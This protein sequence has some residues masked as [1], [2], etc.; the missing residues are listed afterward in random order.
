[1]LEIE[2]KSDEL[3][4]FIYLEL[5][6][7][8]NDPIY[9]EDLSKITEIT[10]NGLDLIG[11][12]TDISIYDLIF[13]KNL[14]TLYISDKDISDK[15]LDIINKL[16]NLRFLQLDNC[17]FSDN[18]KMNLELSGLVINNCP[19]VKINIYSDIKTL[20]TLHIVNCDNVDIS[21]IATLSN[22]EKL[23]LQNLTLEEINE[24]QELKKLEYLS[25]NGSKIKDL[26]KIY[27]IPNLKI[28]NEEIFGIYDEEY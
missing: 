14:T 18:K 24:V 16:S 7:K 28:D 3:K 21:G 19:K 4:E 26:E 10:L 12:P 15:E 5:G 22:L 2:L 27:K 6:K 9:D 17:V 20:E 1:M 13:F 23:F 11:D 25:L 8:S